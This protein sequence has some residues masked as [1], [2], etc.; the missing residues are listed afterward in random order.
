MKRDFIIQKGKLKNWYLLI[1]AFA[2][3]FDSS[4]ILLSF[5]FLNSNLHFAV[6]KHFLFNGTELSKNKTND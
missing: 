4:V 2:M 6:V 3:I 1:R 5:G